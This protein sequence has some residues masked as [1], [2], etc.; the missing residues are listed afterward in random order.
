[1]LA[2]AVALLLSGTTKAAGYQIDSERSQATFGV[3]LLWLH[4]ISGRFRHITGVLLPGSATSS[5]VVDA[6]IALDSVE[7]DSARTRRWLLAPE[8]FDATRYPTIH[9]VSD[10][11]SPAALVRGGNL[12]G[13]LS[14][15]GMIRPVSFE[16]TPSPCSLDAPQLC[17][18]ELHGELQ[19]SDF[20]MNGYRGALSN[21]VDLSLEIA[22]AATLR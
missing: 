1:M 6:N 19:R 3:R 16:L 5:V 21:Q 9:F 2:L 15:R 20:N 11:I 18:I 17:R 7:M 10:P 8:F 14:M 22:L 13:L 4:T 12:T